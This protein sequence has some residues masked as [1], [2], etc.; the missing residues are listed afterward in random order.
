MLKESALA[1]RHVECILYASTQDDP[2]ERD[3]EA[4]YAHAAAATGR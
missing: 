2:P 4:L 3:E 1:L